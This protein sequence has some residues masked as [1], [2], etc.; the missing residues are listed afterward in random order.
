MNNENEITVSSDG[1][2]CVTHGCHLY[3]LL[4]GDVDRVVKGEKYCPI[5]KAERW[6]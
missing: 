6:E 1:T 2:R 4:D 5:C 3:V